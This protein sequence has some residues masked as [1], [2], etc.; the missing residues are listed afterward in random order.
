[1][2]KPI[3]TRLLEML[4]GQIMTDITFL[5]QGTEIKGHRTVVSSYGGPLRALLETDAKQVE[6]PE[7][8]SVTTFKSILQ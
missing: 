8:I 1:M 7:D 4:N 3:G 5:V 2:A 6:I